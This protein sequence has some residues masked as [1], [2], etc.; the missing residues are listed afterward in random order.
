[1]LKEICAKLN[2]L[3][4]E[5]SY[6]HRRFDRIEAY[7]NQIA[8]AVIPNNA[9]EECLAFKPISSVT[10]LQIFEDNLKDTNFFTQMVSLLLCRILYYDFEPVLL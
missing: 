1:M 2:R 10:E 4:V 3:L 6:I 8:N 7:H 9:I 5:V